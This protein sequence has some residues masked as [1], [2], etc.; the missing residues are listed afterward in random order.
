MRQTPS[1]TPKALSYAKHLCPALRFAPSSTS[2]TCNTM[3]MPTAWCHNT[4][5]CSSHS[6][7]LSNAQRGLGVYVRG[8]RIR[9]LLVKWIVSP[10]EAHGRGLRSHNV[11]VVAVLRLLGTLYGPGGGEGTEELTR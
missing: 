10:V 8:H 11:E 9:L 5:Q 7:S 1:R 2:P 4:W 3:P 6:P